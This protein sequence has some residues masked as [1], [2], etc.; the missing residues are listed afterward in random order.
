MRKKWIT[1]LSG[2]LLVSCHQKEDN[3]KSQMII[4]REWRFVENTDDYSVNKNWW[5]SLDDP[6]L[7]SLIDEAIENNRDVLMATSRILQ[8]QEQH[9]QVKAQY[10]PSLNLQTSY[11]HLGLSKSVDYQPVSPK[12][13][14]KQDLYN[15]LLNFSY[16]IDFWGRIRK[17]SEAALYEYLSKVE[18]RRYLLVSLV[19]QLTTSYVQLKQ[20]DNQRTVAALTQQSREGSLKIALTRYKSGLVSLMEVKQ[21]EAELKVASQQLHI[22][23]KLVSLQENLINLLMGRSSEK[24]ERG[25]LLLKN[26]A[27]P[28]IPAGLP[29]DLLKNRP[30][31]RE[32]EQLLQSAQARIGVARAV[33]FPRISLTGI[34]GQR[35]TDLSDLLKN[36]ANTFDYAIQ[37]VLSLFQ[38][39]ALN[40]QLRQAQ[41][42]AK[43]ALFFYEQKVL[44]AFKE[45]E[46]A[47]VS[48]DKAKKIL[49][50]RQQQVTDLQDY[51][52]LANLRYA[53][54]QN[55]YLTVLDSQKSLFNAQLEKAQSEADVYN[56]LIAVY[57]ALGQ[58]WDSEMGCSS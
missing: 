27:L 33:F 53:N 23:E 47:L 49:E 20:Y 17:S 10:W 34:H 38:G 51:V 52:N 24:I 7:V 14:R 36:P 56:T 3:Q 11:D 25:P 32:A 13:N 12:I 45:V 19:S 4:P 8:F 21:A 50:I 42:K 55:D 57:K 48:H 39:G 15:L 31:I 1:C 22:Y 29:S 2:L 35:S 40:A 26:L 37:G 5:K 16:E 54:G 18:A 28:S 58:G 9:A 44:T 46:D 30:D 43:E 6:V 41:H